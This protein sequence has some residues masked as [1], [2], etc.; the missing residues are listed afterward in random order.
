MDALVRALASAPAGT[1]G[2]PVEPDVTVRDARRIIRESATADF[3]ADDGETVRSLLAVVLGRSDAAI[4]GELLGSYERSDALRLRAYDRILGAHG[5]TVRRPFT[6]AQL[7]TVL[8]ALREGLLIRRLVDPEAV[9]DSLYG[10][11]A[12][13]I[14]IAALDTRHRHQHIDEAGASL[15]APD[16]DAAS[17]RPALPDDPRRA[18]I[19]TAAVEFTRHTFY[20]ATLEGMADASGVPLDMLKRLFP[21]KAHIVIAALRPRFTALTQSV[22]DDVSLGTDHATVIRRHLLRCA[23]LTVEERPFMDALIASISYDTASEAEGLVALKQELH[24][25]SL[26]EPVIADGQ[27]LGIFSPAEPAR[28]FAATLMNTLFVRCFSR[29]TLTPEENADFVAD[30]ILDGLRGRADD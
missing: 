6:V 4:A 12:L 20:L 23:R 22:A 16:A 15:A 11:T 30:L 27:R 2:V 21:T 7:A 26:I 14:A 25:P 1:P 8:T 19:D 17:L 29:R 3:S 13:A 18:V 10:E 24:F 28:E 5:A 9:P